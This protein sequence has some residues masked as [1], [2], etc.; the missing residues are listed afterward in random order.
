MFGD[1]H[2]AAKSVLVHIFYGLYGQVMPAGWILLF[3]SPCYT[4]SQ[5]NK[6]QFP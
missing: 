6:S 5:I 4:T 3:K 1:I 2:T